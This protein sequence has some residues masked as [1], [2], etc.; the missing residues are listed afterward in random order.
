MSECHVTAIA[1]SRKADDEKCANKFLRALP[2]SL[3][4]CNHYYYYCC[5]P[6]PQPLSLQLLLL[7]P[8]SCVLLPPTSSYLHMQLWIAHCVRLFGNRRICMQTFL[9]NEKSYR[10]KQ[11]T[12]S[13]KRFYVDASAAQQ[14][15][16]NT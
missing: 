8:P 11:N 1:L 9:T 13:E 12:V 3:S 7:P 15:K 2:L 10:W 5:Y 4:L 14:T 6:P 16:V